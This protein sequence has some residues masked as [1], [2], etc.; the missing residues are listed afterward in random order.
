MTQIK[1]QFILTECDKRKKVEQ[2]GSVV[3]CLT[4]GLRLASWRLT[5]CTVL[6][7]RHFNLCLVGNRSHHE[8]W[9][10]VTYTWVNV[11]NFQNPELY[12]FKFLNLLDACKTE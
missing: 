1:D 2:G 12:Q 10:I 5:R 3:E 7:P 9:L 6:C 8:N 11:Q 4:G